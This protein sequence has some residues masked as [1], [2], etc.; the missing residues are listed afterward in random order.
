MASGLHIK[1]KH[2]K[3]HERKVLFVRN[4]INQVLLNMSELFFYKFTKL[5]LQ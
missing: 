4:V 1:D 2:K 3:R 5:K